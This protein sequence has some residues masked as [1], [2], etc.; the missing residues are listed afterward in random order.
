M[1][2]FSIRS[3]WSNLVIRG[4]VWFQHVW[5]SIFVGIIVTVITLF[6]CQSLIAQE[7]AQNQQ[8]L[9][10]QATN[11]KMQLTDDLQE[12]TLALVRMA[13][14]WEHQ[15]KHS[16]SD[17]E[18]DAA[19]YIQ[20][21]PDYQAIEWVDPSGYVRW[22]VPWQGNEAALNLN[23]TWEPQRRKAFEEAQRQGQIVVTPTIELKQGGRGFL[24]YAPIFQQQTFGG[25]ILGVFRTQQF[26]DDIF[27][28]WDKRVGQKYTIAVFEGNQEIY[29]HS[30]YPDK[31]LKSQ[32][33]CQETTI[34][35][36]GIK[37]RIQV[38]PEQELLNKQNSLVKFLLVMGLFVA[39]LLSVSIFLI[40]SRQRQATRLNLIN[41]NL[42]D[43]ITERQRVEAVLRTREESFRLLV[44]YSPVGIFQTDSQGNCLFVN[45]KWVEM[46]GLSL[47]Q[48]QGTG[49]SN[50]LHPDDSKLVFQQWYSAA[51]T[52]REFLLEYRFLTPQG[53]VTWVRGS[54]VAI[55]DRAGEVT[56]YL[57]T[58][59]DVSDR[60]FAEEALLQNSII[61]RSIIDST[62]DIVFV[63]DAQGRY[64]VVNAA[65]FRW[66]SE[67]IG[68]IIGKNDTE[69][70]EPKTAQRI[71]AA[72]QKIMTT[73]ESL[74]Y[75]EVLPENG[76][77]ITFLTTKFPWRDANGQI[78]GVMGI[79]HDI[80][81]RKQVENE[82]QKAKVAAEAANKA[83]S[84]FL[85]NMSHE[86]RTPLNAILGFS[87]LLQYSPNLSQEEQESIYLIMESG[88]HLLTMINQVLD[89]SKLEA[90]RT[91]LTETSF[92]LIRFLNDLDDMFQFKANLK[93]L[94]LIFDYSDHLPQYIKADEVK[95]KQVLINLLSNALKF[96]EEGGVSVR[97][98][99]MIRQSFVISNADKQR[100]NNNGQTTL[101]F[102]V[103]D[104]GLGIAADELEQLFQPFV[105]T[106]TGI[107]S[108]QGTGL[109]LAISKQ[110][111]KLMGGNLS[112][113]SEVGRGSIFKFDIQ[114]SEVAVKCVETPELPRQVIAL[115]P[116][117][118]SYRILVV[119]DRWD[120]RRLLFKLLS[121]LGF[122]V[123]EASNGQEAI[124]VW[125]SWDPHLIFMD[126][127]MPVMDGYEATQQI[128]AT[129]KGQATALVALSA[130]NFE[131]KQAVIGSI[132]F[133]D[134]IRKPFRE[135]ELFD[136]IT[137]HLGARFIYSEIAPQP[138]SLS[139]E[140]SF[141]ETLAT[142]PKD[143]LASLE[144]SL[145]EGDV[146]LIL[147][148]LKELHSQNDDLANYLF[149]LANQYQ[150]SKLLDLLE[151]SKKVGS[152]K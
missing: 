42:K 73:G 147:N 2:I 25:V 76:M 146:D 96:T 49:W 122:A 38:L 40:Q 50:A 18:A 66:F 64:V 84:I 111:V 108:Q 78:I 138:N 115:E 100:T 20:H 3:H 5:L 34:N 125:S 9:Q 114:I 81:D 123:Q 75:E 70:F 120:N 77:M 124:E 19:L 58:V 53:K 92:D 74:T 90:Q 141:I 88:E 140:N 86:L 52:G 39:V 89:L 10:L 106:K 95:L 36:D 30:H 110:F 15:E 32:K 126:M 151:R 27:N 119:D 63:K 68:T 23:L 144:Q 143:W 134:F 45:P 26:F 98:A 121:P 22:I 28:E 44:N 135:K 99:T 1:N 97:V 85:A 79:S 149:V 112:V 102:E 29:R 55:S 35:F 113:S 46:T 87:Q 136:A 93:G 129:I 142:L 105:Q 133:D 56:G 103:E 128:K 24:I 8:S 47:E 127:R 94:Q 72:D 4:R 48:A 69:I 150:F 101:Y 13:K 67:P 54:A 31:K 145:H 83:K 107:Q 12:R 104:T 51:Q 7:Q 59:T 6:L 109:G 152:G 37:W 139:S 118:P 131:E 11:A 117:Q 116:N 137:K 21:Y 65:V 132:G 33:W 57:G 148:L 16:Q 14:R 41:Q 80:S 43:E 82:L 91:T 62:P 130:S 17:W 61:L 71:I 60:K